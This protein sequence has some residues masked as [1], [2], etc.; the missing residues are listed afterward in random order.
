MF[1]YLIF[2]SLFWLFA[3]LEHFGQKKIWPVSFVL[4]VLVAGLRFETGWDWITYE[5]YFNGLDYL[6]NKEGST[7]KM[8][9]GFN[10]LIFMVKGL[11]GGFQGFLFVVSSSL[12]MDMITTV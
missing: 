3:G 4:F 11:G 6:V 7:L 10:L 1:Y 2:L 5:S 12:G 9:L 8:E